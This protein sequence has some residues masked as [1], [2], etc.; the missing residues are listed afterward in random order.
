M[1]K[2]IALLVHSIL[3]SYESI[4]TATMKNAYKIGE[5]LQ[6]LSKE[7]AKEAKVELAKNANVKE[8]TLAEYKR[9]YVALGTAQIELRKTN[10]DANII[11]IA[12]NSGLLYTKMQLLSK[13][14]PVTIF[15]VLSV[16]ANLERFQSLNTVE[17]ENFK[18]LLNVQH[19]SIADA[20]DNA[21]KDKFTAFSESLQALLTENSIESS[22]ANSEPV[23]IDFR[24]VVQTML[25]ENVDLSTFKSID[26]VINAIGVTFMDFTPIEQTE[27]A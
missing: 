13:V 24:A 20:F 21:P 15:E 22:D 5:K 23:E 6:R 16:P 4:E 27:Q 1:K 14:A 7:D 2:S 25:G 3:S 26:E 19:M 11:D 17:T 12:L 10:K 9:F 8:S 18:H